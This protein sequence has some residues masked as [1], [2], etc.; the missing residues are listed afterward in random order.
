MLSL[1]V[2]TALSACTSAAEHFEAGVG[3]EAQGDI[4]RAAERYIDALEK[5]AKVVL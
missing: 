1:T 4:V 3:L 5:F 2:L